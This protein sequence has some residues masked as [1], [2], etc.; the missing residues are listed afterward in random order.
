[1][2]VVEASAGSGS[3][4]GCWR[5]EFLVKPLIERIVMTVEGEGYISC[6]V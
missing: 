4:Q 6:D 2:S 1:M 5:G 3:R